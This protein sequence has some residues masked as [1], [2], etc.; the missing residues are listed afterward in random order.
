MVFKDK[1]RVTSK[2]FELVRIVKVRYK[3]KNIR[4]KVDLWMTNCFHEPFGESG[5]FRG[6]LSSDKNY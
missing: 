2:P 1:Q 6:L 4:T 3:K 5:I